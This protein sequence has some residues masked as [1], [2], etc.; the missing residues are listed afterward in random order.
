MRR[1]SIVAATLTLA[2]LLAACSGHREEKAQKEAA[3]SPVA[4]AGFV[5]PTALNR[6][7]FVDMLDKRFTQL[8]LNQDSVLETSEV[9][10]R[11]HDQILAADTNH[12]GILTRE[13]YHAA[14]AAIAKAKSATPTEKGWAMVDAQFDAVDQSHT[15]R[16]PRDAFIAAATAHFDGAD[17]NRDGIVTPGEARKAAKMKRKAMRAAQGK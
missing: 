8:D 4:P 15:G 3:N 17:L 9:P 5:P 10:L 12:D 6:T 14:L 11:H 2:V 1:V 13:E 16:I 7:D